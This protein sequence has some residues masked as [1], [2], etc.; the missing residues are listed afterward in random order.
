MKNKATVSSCF[1]L[2]FLALL[3][4]PAAL[5]AQASAPII[6]A[7][8]IS[9]EDK[10]PEGA[11]ARVG[12]YLLANEKLI[13]TID[14]IPNIY[15]FARS[16]GNLRDL[17]RRD[18]M[19]NELE[20][21]F[22]YFGDSFPRQAIYRRIEI[23]ADGSDGRAA[24]VRVS[25]T[26]SDDAQLQVVTDYILEA[27]APY[28]KIFTRLTNRGRARIDK[29]AV[30]DAIQWGET[31]RFAPGYGF[32]AR[33][34]ITAEWIA[35]LGRRVSYA[36][37]ARTGTLEGPQGGSW[38]DMIVA[39]LDLAP[40][41]SAS[42]E[43]YLLAAPDASEL[44]RD[45]F[46]LRGQSVGE[47]TGLVREED[48]GAV[49]AGAEVEFESDGKPQLLVYSGP[50]GRFAAVLPPG[51]Y[52]GRARGLGRGRARAPGSCRQLTIEVGGKS[53]C[54]FYLS[55]QGRL[56]FAVRDSRTGNPIPARL[57]FAGLG[58][59]PDPYFGPDLRA[60][61]SLN[62]L[63]AE[64]GR[65]EIAIAPGLYEVTASRGPEYMIWQK[66]IAV[67]GGKIAS[68]EAELERVLD[69]SGYIS[70][71]FHLHAAPS[72]DSQVPLVDRIIGLIGEGVE[73]AVATDHNMIT[74]Y[75]GTIAELG[76]GSEIVALIGEEVTAPRYHLNAFPLPF[77]P[78]RP[79]N[80]AILPGERKPRELF[81]EIRALPGDEIIQ[82]NHPRASDIGYFNLFQLDSRSG[83]ALHPDYSA[84]Y[85]AIEV[86]NGAAQAEGEQPILDWFGLLNRG[87][88]YT[89]TG[90]SDTHRMAH[91]EAGYPR[92]FI[93]LGTDDPRQVRPEQVVA[94]V[95]E[96]RIV[97]STGPFIRFSAN[98]Q[99][100]GSQVKPENGW[101]ELEISV[102]AAPWVDVSE[103]QLIAN[104]EPAATF[105]VERSQE[106]VRFE[107]KL[108]LRPEADTWYVV[109]ARGSRPLAPAVLAASPR[110][111]PYA[112]TNPIWVDADGN[113]RF[114]PPVKE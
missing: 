3:S 8:R 11:R 81:A 24:I 86:L 49:I 14:D 15:G 87:Y 80:G 4:K 27:G 64:K 10:L 105:L 31:H 71:D 33:G 6:I 95:R 59:S 72:Y 7:K 96:Q 70:G 104:G 67:E 21:L 69:T 16:G 1:S 42:F 38:S 34:R 91:A 41:K 18:R 98:G 82:V 19:V 78:D 50:D 77:R 84:D 13:A 22:T 66:R 103:V 56:A 113:G 79:N 5:A 85:D 30:G 44:Y 46:R 89:A 32:V 68:I 109:I 74:D 48:T 40:G 90:N 39:R 53:E 51:R 12:D 35:G 36:Y 25:G 73:L 93:L 55:Q 76:V 99:P 58:S 106:V 114:D 52:S 101:V 47:I 37:A 112:I 65:G 102:S 60:S 9:G 43:R 61:G 83:R 20:Q 108:R 97:V 110:A 45:L 54:M 100:L 17:A 111:L 88:R 2:L 63:Y 62:I 75:S 28:L 29:F 107:R 26:D 23:A 92:N 94:A 57:T